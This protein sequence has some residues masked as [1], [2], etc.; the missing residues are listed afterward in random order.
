M[1]TKFTKGPWTYDGGEILSH[2]GGG[3]VEVGCGYIPDVPS[4]IGRSHWEHRPEEEDEANAH[5]IKSAPEMYEMLVR[6]K[7]MLI[8]DG[9]Y[10]EEFLDKISGILSDARGDK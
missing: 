6:V 7:S 10:G 5:L 1:E 2:D 4:Q 8:D 3:I 9:G